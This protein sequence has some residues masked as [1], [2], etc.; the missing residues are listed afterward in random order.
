MKFVAIAAVLASALLL[1]E[2]SPETFK[3]VKASEV[4]WTEGPKSA[5]KGVKTCLMH[6][7][8]AKGPF[9]M[10]AKFPAGTKIAPHTHAS[11]EVVSVVSG[12]FVIGSGDKVDEAKGKVVDAGGYFTIKAGTPHWAMVKTE[13]VLV[14]YG[15]GPVDIKYVNPADDPSKK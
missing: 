7:D 9:I 10:L 2:E 8:T 11:D 4:Q 14:R 3:A 12:N 15:N 5:P 6:G 13:A 1:K